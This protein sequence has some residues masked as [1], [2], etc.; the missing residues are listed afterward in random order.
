MIEPASGGE[1]VFVRRFWLFVVLVLV[2]GAELRFLGLGDRSLWF[3]EAFSLSVAKVPFPALIDFVRRNDPHPP[4]YYALLGAWIRLFG[5]SEVAARSLSALISIVTVLLLYGFARRLVSREVAL[6]ATVLLAGSAF[7]VRAGQEVRMYPLLGLLALGSWYA[8]VLAIQGRRARFWALYVPITALMLYTHF[9]GFLVL[10]SQLLYTLPRWRSDGRSAAAAA[11]AAA[12][13]LALFIPWVPVV[14]A[15][16]QRGAGWPTFRPPADLRQAL[17]LLGLFGFGGEL[18]GMGGYFHT[19]GLVMWAAAIMVAPVIGLVGAGLYALRGERAW[20]LSCFWA[21]PIAAALIISQR[22]NVFYPRYFSFLAP[23]FAL[24][25]AAG[26]DLVA[27]GVP[28]LSRAVVVSSLLVL[29]LAVNAPVA[30]GYVWENK[31]D[32]DWRGAARLVTLN[33]GRDDYLLFVPGFAQVPFEYYYKG[34]QDRLQL[35]PVEVFDMARLSRPT[36]P[37]VDKAW[38]RRLAEAHPHVWLI[39]TIPIPDNAWLRLNDLLGGSFSVT[40]TFNFGSVY[41]YVLTSHWPQTP[42]GSPGRDSP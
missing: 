21:A 5:S 18:L 12:T 38:A 40:G 8:M 35:N 7:A 6:A 29:A 39:M 11:L 31:K 32:Y 33:A 25:V 28:R 9:F 24:L 14:I 16:V 1:G 3:D 37:K 20:L 36:A 15:L 22:Y 27:H 19:G 30:Y 10:G 13:V 42:G 26:V 17:D 2:I 34:K 41:V 23:P 4:L